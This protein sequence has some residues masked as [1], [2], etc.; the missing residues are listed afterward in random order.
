[1]HQRANSKAESAFK[2]MKSLLVKTHK[3]GGDPHEAMLEQRNTPHQDTG[4][5][6]AEIMFNRRTHSFLPGM[7][8]SQMDPLV[9]EK[10]DRGT[11]VQC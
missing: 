6:P 11:Q 3:E 7:S 1:M 5:S 2:I 9:K 10:H 4:C 8:N